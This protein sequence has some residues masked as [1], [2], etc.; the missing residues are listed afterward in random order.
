MIL[1]PT[2][3]SALRAVASS[4]SPA[5]VRSR[6]LAPEQAFR[7]RQISGRP[8]DQTVRVAGCTV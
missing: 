3:L 7:R 2:H 1:V 6:A 8:D 4:S 5:S